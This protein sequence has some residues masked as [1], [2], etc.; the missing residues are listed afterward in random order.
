MAWFCSTALTC[1]CNT[2]EANAGGS[3]MMDVIIG[4]VSTWWSWFSCRAEAG[5]WIVRTRGSEFGTPGCGGNVIWMGTILVGS[6]PATTA[7]GAGNCCCCGAWC[8]W[9]CCCCGCGFDCWAFCCCVNAAFCVLP[10]WFWKLL[11]FVVFA[12][13][14]AGTDWACCCGVDC[15]SCGACCCCCCC[16]CGRAFDLVPFD[17]S[18]DV[19][20]ESASIGT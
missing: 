1:C 4:P 3:V 17:C 2:D 9:A 11:W 8:C 15:T 19:N 6:S 5:T 13:F 12:F 7:G 16:A 10:F 20:L 18:N 14:S